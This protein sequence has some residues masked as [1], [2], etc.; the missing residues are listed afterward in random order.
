MARVQRVARDGLPDTY[1][2]VGT[3]HL[4]VSAVEDYFEFLREDGAAANTLR[5]YA[6][7]L[8][9][10]WTL[11]EDTA[12][13]WDNFPTS[14]FGAFLTYLRTGDLPGVDRIGVPPGWLAPAS[15]QARSAAV[16]AFYRFHAQAHGL[17]VPYERL[18]SPYARRGRSRYT[19]F[20]AGIVSPD[21]QR[22]IYAARRGARD[23]TPVLLPNQVQ[24]ILDACSTQ[25]D[26]GW[27]GSESALRDRLLFAV[28]AET[29]MRLGEALS[30]RH[31]DV[32][33]GAGGT[34]WVDIAARQDHPH[35]LRVKSGRPRRIYIGDDLEA[36]YS[37][38]VWQLV[39][40]GADLQVPNLETH[41]V[42]VNLAKGK[43][44]APMRVETVYG[45]VRSITRTADGQ[46]PQGWTPHWFRHTHATALLLSGLA[47]HVVM[48]R[49]GHL[50]EQTTL[51]I[52]GWV[53]AD[54]EMRSIAEWKNYV[55]GWKG[56]HDA[57]Y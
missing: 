29:G 48:R 25:T 54:A 28:L 24:L 37:A 20:L 26:D 39:E 55:A 15:V 12:S 38:Y 19:P 47:P 2:V 32:Q 16:L 33:I 36:L 14:L 50:D 40:Q 44:F 34:P 5:S 53:T 4:P 18:Y 41:F 43:R 6:A 7:G 17:T 46:L 3:D 10:W 31:C 21:K 9:A 27:S 8:A 30:L 13:C 35:G 1:T 49:L 45:K 56:L 51:S 57:A 52:Y 22:P 23:R 42:F 11:L